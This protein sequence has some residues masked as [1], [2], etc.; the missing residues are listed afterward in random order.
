[1]RS[2]G[3]IPQ[4]DAWVRYRSLDD[5]ADPLG[6]YTGLV[7]LL[8]YTGLIH[9]LG[10]TGLVHLQD[11][12]GLIRLRGYTGSA[13][14]DRKVD[15]CALGSATGSKHVSAISHSSILPIGNHKSGNRDRRL[16]ENAPSRL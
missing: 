15:W 10:Y 11:Y 13:I 8:D 9:L 16:K 12:T 3:A 1:M 2:L 6:G 4:C 7:H 14:L 5:W